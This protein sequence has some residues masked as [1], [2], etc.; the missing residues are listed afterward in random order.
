[1]NK[2][3]MKTKTKTKTKPRSRR[4]GTRKIFKKSH[5]RYTKNGMK[6][7]I[8]RGGS[9]NDHYLKLMALL[10]DDPYHQ[11]SNSYM[12]VSGISDH[13][14]FLE[15]LSKRRLFG[16]EAGN[17]SL[18]ELVC[19]DD[20]ISK[21]LMTDFRFIN[22]IN[23]MKAEGITVVFEKWKDFI[24]S[25]RTTISNEEQRKN[26]LDKED[27]NMLKTKKELYCGKA[28][29]EEVGWLKDEYALICVELATFLTKN[30]GKFT[31]DTGHRVVDIDPKAQ[32]GTKPS[33][34]PRI[35]VEP[36]KLDTR[37][38]VPILKKYLD[39][40]LSDDRKGSRPGYSHDKIRY[41]NQKMR[42]INQE[43][44]R[45]SDKPPGNHLYTLLTQKDL[46]PVYF[47]KGDSRD[48]SVSD[49]N[50]LRSVRGGP[51]NQSL[52][53]SGKHHCRTCGRCMNKDDT[54]TYNIDPENKNMFL[55][56]VCIDCYN[57]FS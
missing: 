20:D 10:Y 26:S 17:L 48:D 38:F 50:C 5:K 3:K 56:P 41:F 7:R 54:Q 18:E 52:F 6:R 40:R 33:A 16:L 11:W 25:I 49:T 15:V 32:Y 46:I 22:K 1:M 14:K 19:S 47:E 55:N 31:S 42:E 44:Q 21:K 23:E 36:L 9:K 13:N 39:F 4:G 53:S 43:L 51:F 24:N 2:R 12:A 57:L 37:E 27:Y 34:I 35:E 45:T 30:E 29:T 8:Q 28:T